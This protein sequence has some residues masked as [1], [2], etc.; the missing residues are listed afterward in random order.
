[1]TSHTETLFATIPINASADHVFA[2]LTNWSKQSEWIVGTKVKATKQKGMGV[3]G[4]ISAFTGI[5][6][7]GFTDTMVIT[8][9]DPP[10]RCSVRHTGKI[11]K[12][13]GDFIVQSVSDHTATFT[14]SE[15]FIIPFGTVGKTAWLI[16]RPFARLGLQVSLKQFARRAES[17]L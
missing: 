4:E 17:L 3:G 15:D 7:L 16:A 9:W 5:G 10:R 11:V 6:P 8:A 1:M 14:W 12:G 13:T 2:C